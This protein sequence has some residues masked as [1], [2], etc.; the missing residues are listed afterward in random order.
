MYRIA[1]PLALL[2]VAGCAC[3][4]YDLIG[5]GSLARHVGS[6]ATWFHLDPV[7]YSL[8]SYDN[9]LVM[10]VENPNDEPVQLL[11]NRCRIIDPMGGSHPVP[12]QMIE[13]GKSIKM[14]FPPFPNQTQGPMFVIRLDNT[15]RPAARPTYTFDWNDDLNVSMTLVY[16]YRDTVVEDHLV[17]HRR[18]M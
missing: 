15:T 16:F 17:F 4:E 8:V 5:P 7:N 14:I 10:T 12:D 1:L 6:A 18:K 13:P 11:G 3:Y 9:R 2:L